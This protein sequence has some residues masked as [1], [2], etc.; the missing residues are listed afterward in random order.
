[1][2]DPRKMRDVIYE[3]LQRYPC[4]DTDD[5]KVAIAIATRL[6]NEELKDD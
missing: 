5:R 2:I 6:V 1:M 4:A 3:V